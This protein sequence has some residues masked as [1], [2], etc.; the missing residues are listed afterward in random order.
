MPPTLTGENVIYY[1]DNVMPGTD[2]VCEG[3]YEH[4]ARVEPNPVRRRAMAIAAYPPA[5]RNFLEWLYQLPPDDPEGPVEDLVIGGGINAATYCAN[6]MRESA[7]TPLVLERRRSLG[8]VF[9]FA[10]RPV[11]FLNSRNRSDTDAPGFGPGTRAPLNR[12]PGGLLQPADADAREYQTQDVLGF[13]AAVYLMYTANVIRGLPVMCLQREG[14]GYSVGTVA[15]NFTARRVIIATGLGRE[16]GL[17]FGT[18]GLSV[19]PAI[20]MTFSQFVFNMGARS[21]TVPLAG[22]GRVAVVGAGDSGNVVVEYL[23]GQGPQSGYSTASLDSVQS[24]TWIGQECLTREQFEDN[25]R[26]RYKGIGRFMRRE[27]RPEAPYKLV[28]SPGKVLDVDPAP[29]DRVRLRWREEPDGR[30]QTDV[31]DRVVVCTGFNPDMPAL[32]GMDEPELHTIDRVPAARK[33]PGEEIYLVGPCAQ[34]PVSEQERLRT[35]LLETI[36]G[37]SAA[38]FRYTDRTAALARSFPA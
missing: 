33:V 29:N 21:N 17:E 38:L 9:G 5:R 11:F 19:S 1:W 14:D 22:W 36:P 3:L 35:P 8:G 7:V 24:V 15:R 13:V 26:S 37:N 18:A 23:L 25:A 31:F 30:W 2:R 20:C 32:I 6:R 16:V 4:A 28:A 12:I 34:L 10:E 27:E